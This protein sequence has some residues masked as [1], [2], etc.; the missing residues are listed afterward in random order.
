MQSQIYGFSILIESSF[1][2]NI[3]RMLLAFS[4][5]SLIIELIPRRVG[6]YLGCLFSLQYII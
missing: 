2:A 3:L 1:Q 6:G 5:I 4:Y